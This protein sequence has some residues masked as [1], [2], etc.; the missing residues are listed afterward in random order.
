MLHFAPHASF[1]SPHASCFMLPFP[2]ASLYTVTKRPSSHLMLHLHS[3]Q[4][5]FLSPHA[6]CSSPHASCFLFL[7][8]CFTLHLMLHLTSCFTLHSDQVA[9]LS[10]HASLCTS[11]FLFLTSCFTLHLMLHLTSCFTLPPAH[12]SMSDT[13]STKLYWFK[14]GCR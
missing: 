2:H 4:V 3:D 14:V 9:F 11:C 7:T 6:S 13:S 10:P 1:S 8:S 5:A 12:V